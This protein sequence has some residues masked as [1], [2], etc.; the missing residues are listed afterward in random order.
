MFSC[1]NIENPLST[2]GK[3][4]DAFYY[5]AHN[6]KFLY[7]VKGKKYFFNERTY[8]GGLLKNEYYTIIY[9]S[10]DPNRAKVSFK[11]PVIKG[12]KNYN[13]TQGKVIKIEDQQF[14][15]ILFQYSFNGKLYERVQYSTYKVNIGD[16]I[17][18]LVNINE[19]RI[20]Y[21]KNK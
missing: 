2:E 1:Y 4:V 21:I 17:S 7:V 20:S 5:K 10:L 12:I 6:Y 19:P 11:D 14:N 18:I 15:R 8:I 16:T 3:I 13:Q 9:D